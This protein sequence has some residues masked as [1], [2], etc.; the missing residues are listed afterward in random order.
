MVESRVTLL[1]GGELSISWGR[2]GTSAG[3]GRSRPKTPKLWMLAQTCSL[4]DDAQPD[5]RVS[6]KRRMASTWFQLKMDAGGSTASV[7]EVEPQK[8]NLVQCCGP[9]SGYVTAQRLLGQRRYLGAKAGLGS[10]LGASLRSQPLQARAVSLA[11]QAL[12][13]TLAAMRPGLV[14]LDLARAASPA[15]GKGLGALAAEAGG[16]GDCGGGRL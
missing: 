13:A 1:L 11:G 9:T 15:A 12:I 8:L 3:H 6:M 10:G 16:D 4:W 5:S 7:N 14:A 2:F